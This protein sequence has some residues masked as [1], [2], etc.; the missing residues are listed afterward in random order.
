MPYGESNK[1]YNENKSPSQIT[2]LRNSWED[3]C[4]IQIT[5]FTSLAEGFQFARLFKIYSEHHFC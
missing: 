3:F 2:F 4:H 5:I 1:L